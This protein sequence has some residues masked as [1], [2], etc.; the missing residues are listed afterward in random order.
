MSQQQQQQQSEQPVSMHPAAEAT[1]PAATTTIENQ[2]GIDIRDALDILSSRTSNY[3][4]ASHNGI[5][6]HPEISPGCC[7]CC[8]SGHHDEMGAFNND[9]LKKMG[10]TID[11]LASSTPLSSLTQSEIRSQQSWNQVQSQQQQKQQMESTEQQQQQQ[12]QAELTKI[13]ITTTLQSMTKTSD[14]LQVLLRAQ[15]DR[16]QTYRIYN[17]AL[18]QVLRTGNIT[19]YP[20]SCA[21]A[22]ASFA[23]L[24]DTIRAVVEEMSS[25]ATTTTTNGDGGGTNS[26]SNDNF[27]Q[28]VQWIKELQELE[29]EKLQLTAAL[30][31]EK[32]RAN[33]EKEFNQSGVLRMLQH[34]IADLQQ[35]MEGCIAGINGVLED[36]RGALVE[37]MEMEEESPSIF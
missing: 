36:L 30:H 5:S 35:K 19:S 15:E 20:A 16:V 23:M 25:R 1:L 9:D 6:N 28:Y 3:S 12:Q 29:K 2:T 17:S 22:T 24:S 26:S 18:Q 13:T 34:G 11:M 10:Q 27:K 4:Y 14:L 33:N 32:I 31:L 21:V 7:R 37:E 8:H